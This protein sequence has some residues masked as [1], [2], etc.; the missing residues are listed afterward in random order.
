MRVAILCNGRDLAFWQRQ[1]VDRIAGR[2][3]IFILACSEPAPPSRRWK[4]AAY[5]A[6]NLA[7]IR[8]RMTKR[9]PFPAAADVIAGRIDV[10]P[11]MDGAWAI[12]PAEAI[13]WLIENRV[14]SIVKFGLNLLRVPPADELPIP[15]LS[16]HHGD[17]RRYRGRPAG[18]Y[19]LC[20]GDPFVGQVVQILT[21]KLDAGEIVAFAESRAVPHSYRRTLMAAYA[22]S[23]HLLP[24]ALD[25]VGSKVRIDIAANG[26]NYRLP[27]TI[28]VVRFVLQRIRALLRLLFYGALIEKKWRIATCDIPQAADPI[29]AVGEAGAATWSVPPV[30]RRFAFYADPFFHGDDGAILAEAL[31]RWS[32]KGEVVNLANGATTSLS[33]EGGHLSYPATV[34]EDGRAY[35]IPESSEW[36][37]A[38]IYEI[39]D[40]RL[41]RLADLDVAAGGLLDP[42]PFRAGGHVYLFANSIEDGPSILHLWSAPSIFGRFDLHPCS[43]VRISARGSRMAGQVQPWPGGLYR[44]GQDSRQSYGDGLLAFRIKSLSPTEYA[45]EEAGSAAFHA[46]RGPHTLNVSAGTMLFDFYTERFSPLAGVRRMI[47]KL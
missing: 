43:P 12:L 31:N 26:R 4:H 16:Y 39:A 35:V 10:Q 29:S 40:G 11:A 37:R 5:Y 2:H 32:G 41:M 17:P 36:S 21:N 42:T 3:E 46:V 15:I 8:N 22:L 23:P 19:E 18:F 7:S 1:A 25:A 33:S 13:A 14:D 38:G 27:G 30:D 24:V 44:I 47:G 34:V 6:L 9:V 28:Q 20:N 45:E